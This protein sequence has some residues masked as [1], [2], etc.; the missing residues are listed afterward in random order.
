MMTVDAQ[1]NQCGLF[2]KALFDGKPGSTV[3]MIMQA[4]RWSEAK[5]FLAWPPAIE[6]CF[7]QADV[8][9]GCCALKRQ[10]GKGSRGGESEAAFLPGAWIDVD[11][12]G[13]PDGRGG[14]VMG[15][16][17]SQDAAIKSIKTLAKP[18]LAVSSGYGLHI[19][20]LL[21][22]QFAL[23]DAGAQRRAKRI[24]HGIQRRLEHEAGWK[25]DNT[26]D[27]ARVL[28]VPGTMNTKG[29]TPVDVHIVYSG[30]P[31]YQLEQ[32]EQLGA[33]HAGDADT[34]P[35]PG[36]SSGDWAEIIAAGAD[37]GERHEAIWRLAGY[38]LRR[39]IDPVVALELVQAFNLARVRPP[40]DEANVKRLFDG[41][42]RRE[43][44]RRREASAKRV[45]ALRGGSPAP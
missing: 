45:H 6:A 15:H 14:R 40:Y 41:I 23:A 39:E 18:T 34:G 12:N 4:P 43:I 8:Y 42:V 31:R 20:Y 2:L 27:L 16:A 26:A 22:E 10:P 13:S 32:L 30:G 21:A 35:K 24:V 29:D 25:V 44:K 5:A 9:V 28:R 36:R 3:V 37:I 1:R 11:I 33:E 19:W 7:S 38:L 17:P